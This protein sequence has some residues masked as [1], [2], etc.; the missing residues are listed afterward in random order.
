VLTVEGA[1]DIIGLAI[2]TLQPQP[3]ILPTTLASRDLPD[4]MLYD[5]PSTP[6]PASEATPGVV[7]KTEELPMYKSENYPAC[8]SENTLVDSFIGTAET[9]NEPDPPSSSEYPSQSTLVHRPK[10]SATSLDYI[11]DSASEDEGFAI[12]RG[13]KPTPEEEPM[14]SPEIIPSNTVDVSAA[15]GSNYSDDDDEWIMI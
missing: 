11:L 3:G 2:D 13:P 8:N 9:A 5:R 15:T 12:V 4:V 14:S 1:F 6:Q 10:S 7:C